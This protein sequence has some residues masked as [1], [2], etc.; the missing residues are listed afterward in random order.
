MLD[1]SLKN[2]VDWRVAQVIPVRSGFGYRVFLKY[3]NGSEKPQ[4][5][6][7]FKTER[8]LISAVAFLLWEA[9]SRPPDCLE[10]L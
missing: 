10:S 6:S 5:K 4:Q 3:P 7:G 2:Y 9:L 8:I 1:L